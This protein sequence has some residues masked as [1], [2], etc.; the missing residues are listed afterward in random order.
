M[1]LNTT[2]CGR[3][4]KQ[5]GWKA[6]QA[7]CCTARTR[8]C[9][10]RTRCCT[11][12]THCQTSG[13]HASYERVRAVH[14][15]GRPLHRRQAFCCTAT[16]CR[17]T[18]NSEPTYRTCVPPDD[19]VEQPAQLRPQDVTLCV[20]HSRS[21]RP[22]AALHVDH[23]H[24]SGWRHG[25]WPCEHPCAVLHVNHRPVQGGKCGLGG[26]GGDPSLLL[27]CVNFMQQRFQGKNYCWTGW[28]RPTSMWGALGARSQS[29][30]RSDVEACTHVPVL[31]AQ[32]SWQ[33]RALDGPRTQ[34]TCHATAQT[35]R[36][37]STCVQ[38]VQHVAMQPCSDAAN[39][40]HVNVQPCRDA[41]MQPCSDAANQPH[42]NMHP[43]S[44]ARTQPTSCKGAFMWQHTCGH[45]LGHARHQRVQ[46]CA[47]IAH[48]CI[49]RCGCAH[50]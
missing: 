49:L 34:E 35:L 11:A 22:Q 10:A 45:D 20:T 4:S 47:G 31:A 37:S 14:P 26:G 16:S 25:V 17:C 1:H 39:Q 15:A 5:P 2:V 24:L 48:A 18:A 3:P 21:E 44:H 7:H 33:G 27:A 41:A 38:H 23:H 29:C 40:L 19:C 30:A 9:T 42:V 50:T 36:C 46:T 8:C 28:R 43:C 13:R 12:Q 6:R 32:W